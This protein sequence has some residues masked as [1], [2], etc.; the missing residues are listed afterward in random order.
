MVRVP[1]R[2]EWACQFPLH[3]KKLV[4]SVAAHRNK[5]RTHNVYIRPAVGNCQVLP[6]ERE[7]Q[8]VDGIPGHMSEAEEQVYP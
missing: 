6:I 3:T 5:K 4:R 1:R 8:C 2:D 7:A